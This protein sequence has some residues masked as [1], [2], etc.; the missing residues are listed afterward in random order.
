MTQNSLMTA[1]RHPERSEGSPANDARCAN[2]GRSLA[3][4]GMT[5]VAQLDLSFGVAGGRTV[6]A[7]RH[8]SYPF[9]V[10]APLQSAES[11]AD[12]IVQS[13]SGGVYGG[14]QLRQRVTVDAG[15]QAVIRMP[16]ATVVHATRTA[17]PARQSVS[18][19]AGEG[20]TLF[21]LPRPLILFPGG[22][23]VQAMD[24]TVAGGAT[25]MIRD[26]FLLHDPAAM[27]SGS[28]A[29]RS[30]VTVRDAA[31]RLIAIDLLR[32]DDGMID[33]AS[34]GVTGSYR[35]FGTVWLVRR[36]EAGCVQGVK[37]TIARRFAPDGDCYVST[38]SLRHD[39]GAI[40]R[41]AAVDGG[42]LD[43]ALEAI[44]DAWVRTLV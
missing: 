31:G 26:G 35:A 17:E 7:R 30:R 37:A 41:V 36:M 1:I 16:S 24:I 28:R 27:A 42:A 10:T 14:E 23:L 40:V 11:R 2:R 20:A 4:P 15:A 6:L 33:A 18:L 44:V 34:P 13:A 9:N 21:Y 12:V 43:V 8:V 19:Q 39:A 22:A 3:S 29:L 32:I 25:V 38:T 5:D